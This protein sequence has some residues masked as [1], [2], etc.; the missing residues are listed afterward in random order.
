MA[1]S[2][3][4]PDDTNDLVLQ[5]NH[6]ASKIEVNEDDTIVV[7]SGGNFTIDATGDIIL[8]AGGADVTLK[9]DGTTYGS[10]KQA[11]GDFIIQPASGEQIVLNDEGGDSAL[12][13]DTEGNTTLTIS[14]S[15]VFSSDK[16]Y[17]QLKGGGSGAIATEMVNNSGTTVPYF[18][19]GT[20]D[21]TN[22]AVAN[23]HDYQLVKTGVYLI[24]FSTSFYEPTTGSE[25][26]FTIEIR[27]NLSSPTTSEGTDVLAVSNGQ[28]ANTADGSTDFGGATCSVVH[29][30]STANSLINFS[31]DE[32]DTALLSKMHASIILIRQT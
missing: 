28:V 14:D 25:N 6:G 31:L 5:N 30:F 26:L 20:G 1:D 22:I 11:S 16:Y 2:T 4:K 8:D 10:L 27:T 21:T 17:L 3:V 32:G 7:T 9:D 13:I 24:I 15:S 19:A 23:T 18:L 12:E 29:N